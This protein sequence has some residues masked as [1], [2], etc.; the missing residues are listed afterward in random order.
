[1]SGL[2]EPCAVPDWLDVDLLQ[3]IALFVATFVAWLTYRGEKDA[4]KDAVLERRFDHVADRVVELGAA[5]TLH[6]TGGH[7]RC[8]CRSRRECQARDRVAEGAPAQRAQGES[9]ALVA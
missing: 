3:T 7:R 5:L 9:T 6:F 4:R 1:M 8:A 2:G